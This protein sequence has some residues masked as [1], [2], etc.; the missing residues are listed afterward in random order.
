MILPE[1]QTDLE[2]IQGHFWFVLLFLRLKMLQLPT[3]EVM[4]YLKS[5]G[6]KK[7]NKYIY[8]FVCVFMCVCVNEFGDLWKI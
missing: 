6:R 4:S 3:L 7:I 2:V 1:S 8:I 5:P